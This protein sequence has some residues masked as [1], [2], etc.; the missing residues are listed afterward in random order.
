MRILLVDDH[1]D[2]LE[3]F[4]ALLEM[5]GHEV[6]P[7]QRPALA[8][9]TALEFLPDVVFL[10]LGMPEMDG[11]EVA[12]LLRQHPRL[13]GLHLVAV[14]GHG[15]EE[16][17]ARGAR[18]DAHLMKPVDPRELRGFIQRLAETRSSETPPAPFSRRLDVRWE[19]GARE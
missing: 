6:R 9:S 18:F 7:V 2:T 12:R 13:E 3:I 16:V 1:R 15:I 8:L 14:T 11:S 17:Q 19:K 5:W 4:S 10:D